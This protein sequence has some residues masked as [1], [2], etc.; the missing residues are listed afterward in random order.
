[1]TTQ[2]APLDGRGH[3]LDPDYYQQEHSSRAPNSLGS[4]QPSHMPPEISTTSVLV[5][6]TWGVTLISL[7]DS[8][9]IKPFEDVIANADKKVFDPEI[10]DINFGEEITGG[11]NNYG[12][13][14]VI[15]YRGQPRN[16][17]IAKFFRRATPHEYGEVN[18]LRMVNLLVESGKTKDPHPLRKS[19]LLPVIIMKKKEG[20]SCRQ[21]IEESHGKDSS[22][23][24]LLDMWQIEE[25]MCKQAAKDAVNFWVFHDDNNIDN[26]LVTIDK[27]SVKVELVDYGDAYM[28]I[29]K[30]TPEETFYKACRGR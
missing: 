2:S 16:D 19:S 12:I 30:S 25:T 21:F 18:A 11:H 13:W 27:G 28:V 9:A 15:K 8:G 4:R 1:M 17:L 23:G 5:P 6:R 29:D 26:G 20:I 24:P 7:L 14:E 10:N 3:A 22:Q